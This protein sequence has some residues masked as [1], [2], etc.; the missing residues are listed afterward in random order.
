[1]ILNWF[2]NSQWNEMAW[3]N[4]TT[5]IEMSVACV[6]LV[7]VL[8]PALNQKKKWKKK[9]PTHTLVSALHSFANYCSFVFDLFEVLRHKMNHVRND[10]RKI[11]K[12]LT[13]SAFLVQLFSITGDF[14]F[15]P[16][17]LS[18][19]EHCY[20]SFRCAHIFQINV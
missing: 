11:L 12:K 4:A 14:R 7:C 1:M 5:L 20:I 9:C 3:T 17:Q 10:N 6:W 8:V 15:S 18:N 13:W 16:E 2:E 19:N